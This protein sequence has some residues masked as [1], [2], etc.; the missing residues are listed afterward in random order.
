M[1][2]PLD[3]QPEGPLMLGADSATAA[4]LDF[5]PVGDK[6]ANPVDVFV[7]YDFYMLDAEGADPPAGRVST[8]GTASRAAAAAAAWPPATSGRS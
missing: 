5:G 2:G 6:P 7:I 8:P 3:G 4:R 1:P